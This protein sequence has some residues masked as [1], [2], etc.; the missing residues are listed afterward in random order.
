MTNKQA[1]DKL[2]A[3]HVERI[4]SILQSKGEDAFKIA[5]N[6]VV[7]P[8]VNDNKEEEWIRVTISIPKG[9]RDG[10]KFDGYIEKDDYEFRLARK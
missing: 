5:S 10:E 4:L 9:S 8:V 1:N 7:Y 6:V 3:E 2:R